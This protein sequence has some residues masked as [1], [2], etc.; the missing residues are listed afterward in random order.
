MNL[1]HVGSE[2]TPS[3]S[4]DNLSPIRLLV[5]TASTRPG[6]FGPTVSHWFM[7]HA[8]SRPEFETIAL[9]LAEIDPAGNA[10]AAALREVDAVILITPEYNHSFPG[11][12]KTAI[13]NVYNEWRG[14]PIGFVS[15]GGRSGGLRAVEALRGVLAELHALTVRETVSLPNAWDLFGEDGQPL[16]PNLRVGAVDRM[17][18]QLKWWAGAVSAGRRLAT[19]PE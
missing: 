14:L 11:P 19:Y 13:D 6:R 2:K 1:S 10:V 12:L 3:A 8:A 5:I 4:L 18:N 17:L 16:D 7:K 15:Y 9:D